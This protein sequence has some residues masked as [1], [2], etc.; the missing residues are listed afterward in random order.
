MIINDGCGMADPMIISNGQVDSMI[1]AHDD[2]PL[3]VTIAEF[4]LYS[5]EQFRRHDR[6]EISLYT[7]INN[8]ITRS[9]YVGE[10]SLISPH[11]VEPYLDRHGDRA[12]CAVCIGVYLLDRLDYSHALLCKTALLW[13]L[14]ADIVDSII[15]LMIVDLCE[16]EDSDD[17]ED[18]EDPLDNVLLGLY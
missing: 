12:I 18:G 14:H 13:Y 4:K 3:R 1:M 15:A 8:V 17:Y 6:R 2:Y 16:S 10:I 9:G 5:E 11:H 7:T